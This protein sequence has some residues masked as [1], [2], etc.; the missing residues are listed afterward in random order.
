M[1]VVT[2]SDVIMEEMCRQGRM[3]QASAAAAPTE[4]AAQLL[5]KHGHVKQHIHG[6]AR[7]T[8]KR[9]LG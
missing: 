8:L 4:Q 9:M 5:H 1:G 3:A 2:A 6:T 7:T